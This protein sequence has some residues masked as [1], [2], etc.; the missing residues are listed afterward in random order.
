MADKNSFAAKARG[1]RPSNLAQVAL[2]NP[3]LSPQ[4]I[5]ISTENMHQRSIEGE[6]EGE[7]YYS[8]RQHNRY[9]TQ[10]KSQREKERPGFLEIR[11]FQNK[12]W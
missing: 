4:H 7:G 3:Y 12:K 5:I 6:G 1:H 9:R 2:E 11:K 10:T 8:T